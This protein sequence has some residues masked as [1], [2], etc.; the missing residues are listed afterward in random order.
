[1]KYGL[2]FLSLICKMIS[3]MIWNEVNKLDFPI[4]DV[5]DSSKNRIPSVVNWLC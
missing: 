5:Y 1:M 3:N 2:S 4:H